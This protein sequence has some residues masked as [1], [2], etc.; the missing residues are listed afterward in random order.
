M[1]KR[2]LPR[3]ANGLFAA[4]YTLLAVGKRW[5]RELNLRL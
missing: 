2:P 4:H 1:S 5:R 3:L